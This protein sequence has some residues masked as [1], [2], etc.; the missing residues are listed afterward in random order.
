MCIYT[1]QSKPTLQLLKQNSKFT[2]STDKLS[3]TISNWLILFTKNRKKEKNEYFRTTLIVQ[4][5]V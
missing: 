5:S 1:Q 3:C 2:V 4:Y